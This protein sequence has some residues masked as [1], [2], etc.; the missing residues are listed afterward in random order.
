MVSHLGRSARALREERRREE[1]E[2]EEEE[3]EKKKRKKKR[4]KRIPGM[5]LYGFVWIAMVLYG[6][7]WIFDF[8]MGISFFHF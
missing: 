6:F 2:E 1:E 8:Y 4:E 3:E 7:V 5:D